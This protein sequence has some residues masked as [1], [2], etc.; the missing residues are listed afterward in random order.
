MKTRTLVFAVCLLFTACE[1]ETEIPEAPEVHIIEVRETGKIAAAWEAEAQAL[2]VEAE[3]ALMDH[4]DSERL[5]KGTRGWRDLEAMYR[6]SEALDRERIAERR[7]RAARAEEVSLEE[8][9]REGLDAWVQV[10]VNREH[11]DKW[12]GD[13]IMGDLVK[14]FDAEAEAWEPVLEAWMEVVEATE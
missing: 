3:W 14:R 2:E 10:S 13:R 1:S 5:L 12:R 11:A 8:A 9:L 6:E 7:E 4:Q